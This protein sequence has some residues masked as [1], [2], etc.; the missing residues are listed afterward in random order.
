MESDRQT[1]RDMGILIRQHR[2]LLS[3]SGARPKEEEATTQS[4]NGTRVSKQSMRPRGPRSH[5]PRARR[6][7]LRDWELPTL[8]DDLPLSGGGDPNRHIGA[9][10]SI[11]QASR[12]RLRSGPSTA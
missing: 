7:I 5:S 12:H 3:T 6:P 4:R 1:M 2:P 11:R 10:P 8:L 9:V